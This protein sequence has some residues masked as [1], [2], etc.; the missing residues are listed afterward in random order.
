M[1]D[2]TSELNAADSWFQFLFSFVETYQLENSAFQNLPRSDIMVKGNGP[3]R[4]AIYSDSCPLIAYWNFAVIYG[5]I[6][7]VLAL[8]HLWRHRL[9]A[10]NWSIIHDLFQ[11][12][13]K[14]VFETACIK[15]VRFLF[16][17]ILYGRHINQQDC[18]HPNCFPIFDRNG[19]TWFWNVNMME[20]SWGSSWSCNWKCIRERSNE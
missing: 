15:F 2:N 4:C 17:K 18:F 14:C 16:A 8:L 12:K 19:V 6:V 20:N 10:K 13:K 7:I 5:G 11:I 3:I 9:C 1:A